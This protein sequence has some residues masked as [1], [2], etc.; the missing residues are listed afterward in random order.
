MLVISGYDKIINTVIKKMR[1]K[2]VIVSVSRRTDIP[3]FYSDWFI[4]KIEQGFLY[5]MNPFNRKQVSKLV[6]T[7]DMVDCFVFWTKDA[8][9]LMDKLHMLDERG[10]K[11]YF[12]FTITPYDKDIEPGVRDKD[13]ILGTFAEL[14]QMI[15][16]EKVIW[17]YDPIL[18]SDKY[19]KE[20]HYRKFE[21]YCDRLHK[22]TEKCVISFLDMYMKTKRNTKELGLTDI[23]AEDMLELASKLSMAAE[24]Y[25]LYIETCSE[26]IDLSSLNI[27]K[28]RCIDDRLI[29]RIL[30]YPIDVKRDKNQ[31][32]ACGC[33]K[34]IDIGQY[35]TCRHFCAYCYA[36]YN[37]AQVMESCKTF[38]IHSP[39]LTGRL[40]NDEAIIIRDATSTSYK[41]S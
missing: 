14:S 2:P 38:D 20:F 21:E 12:Q 24:N 1:S 25:G 15:G 31:R 5:V 8:A 30:G 28:G 7:P 11:Y 29:E 17:R 35:N 10:F 23:K 16:R 37:H 39:L 36:N 3:A 4:D 26:V 18:L 6:L 19:N 27:H 22:Y 40:Q 33:V 9:P 13:E 32:E 41:Q 34:S